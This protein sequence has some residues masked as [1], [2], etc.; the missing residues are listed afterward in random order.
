MKPKKKIYSLTLIVA[1]VIF[2][3]SNSFAQAESSE[4]GKIKVL[5]DGLPV[6]FDAPPIIQDQRTLVPFRA[7]AEALNI[8]V[9]WDEKTRTVSATDGMNSVR[10]QVG[11]KTAYRNDTPILLDTAPILL[12]GRTLIPV[13]FFSEA[14]RCDV[15]WDGAR[16]T[17]Q[18]TSPA[19]EMNLI[20]FYALGDKETSSWTDLFSV[21]YPETSIGNTDIVRELALGWY[22]VDKE[23]NL[24]TKSKTGWQ[25]PDGWEKV[26]ETSNEFH[27]R[28]EMVVH[29]T[30]GDGTLSS[31]LGDK[32]A[33][34]RVVNQI[35]AEAKLFD[36]INLDFEGLGFKDTDEQR[37]SV[38]NRFSEFVRLLAEELKAMDKTLTL[39]LHAPNSAYPGYDYKTLG[40]IADKIIVMAYDYGTKPE[41]INLVVQAVE[42]AKK[43]VPS[44]KLILGISAPTETA[45]S[46]LTKIGVAKR[47]DLDGIA[48]WRLGVISDEMWKNIK[49]SIL[50]KLN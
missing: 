23:G 41:P 37:R 48:L 27:L 19:K 40:E 25:R 10:L 47:Y 45:E 11:N 17:V 32:T 5:I 46:M 31:L 42:M 20:G 49:T 33:M 43:D 21:P 6:T 16:K 24:L 9:S 34:E 14:F 3:V 39:T 2:I 29:A 8:N 35:V 26:L 36:G 18:I 22:S 28:T 15:V 4:Q 13:R 30:D 12:D 44:D 1:L 50:P 7:I 38:Q